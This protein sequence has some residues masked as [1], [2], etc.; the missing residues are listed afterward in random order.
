MQIATTSIKPVRPFNRFGASKI[1]GTG[2]D[3]QGSYKNFILQDTFKNIDVKRDR[4]EAT[5]AETSIKIPA[6]QVPYGTT[7][8]TYKM[9]LSCDAKLDREKLGI[10]S[11]TFPRNVTDNVSFEPP[12]QSRPFQAVFDAIVT[13]PHFNKNSESQHP[14]NP[15]PVTVQN[16][17]NR[18]G[19]PFDI[20]NHLPLQYQ[21]G[22]SLGIMDKQVCNRRKGITEFA[23]LQSLSS[24]NP[25][26]ENLKALH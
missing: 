22:K 1:A 3:P 10:T 15:R 7:T 4:F 9:G 18:S 20:V 12:E 13:K 23:D 11:K 19:G 25:G 16:I 8:M 6:G 17:N 5:K 24:L 26:L 21:A 2:S 14:W